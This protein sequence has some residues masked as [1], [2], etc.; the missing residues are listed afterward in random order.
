[1][2]SVGYGDIAPVTTIGKVVAMILMIAGVGAYGCLAG[3]I[4][5]H[6]AR[7]SSSSNKAQ[8]EQGEIQG[9]LEAIMTE[10]R[11]LKKKP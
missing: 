1:M 9:K 11:E 7:S 6:L 8:K 3:F 4:G 5:G 2:A 10:L